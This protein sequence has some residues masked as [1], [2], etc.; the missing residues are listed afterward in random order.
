[1]CGICG[2]IGNMPKQD[3]EKMFRLNESRGGHAWGMAW[4]SENGVVYDKAPGR[5]PVKLSI[6]KTNL[7][8]AHTRFAT[9]GPAEINENNH[10]HLAGNLVLVH[11]G[12][13]MNK[14]KDQ[15][16]ACDSEAIVKMIFNEPHITVSETRKALEKA[17]ENINGSFRIAMLNT[18]TPNILYLMCDSEPI[19]FCI[20][21]DCV[22]FASEAKDLKHLKGGIFKG[23]PESIYIITDQLMITRKEFKPM[24]KF[25]YC[26][27]SHSEWPQHQQI[28]F[29][30]ET[31]NHVTNKW[32][33]KNEK[34]MTKWDRKEWLQ[35]NAPELVE[36][37][38]VKEQES[39]AKIAW[40]EE[41]TDR[42]CVNCVYQSYGGY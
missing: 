42:D 15:K 10:P 16:T 11:N 37:K 20:N 39:I 13:V 29:R 4:K 36:N 18:N 35:K 38:A 8:I 26:T 21:H 24:R 12:V 31:Y 22:S 27:S 7:M 5:I 34:D 3:F 30:G 17:G 19:Y 9:H 1:M 41:C 14:H 23:M 28:G 6:P 40:C 2:Y 25:S 32:E 33:K